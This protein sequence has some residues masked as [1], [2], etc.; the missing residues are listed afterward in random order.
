MKLRYKFFLAFL[1]AGLGIVALL[2]GGMHY[3]ASRNFADY[4]TNEAL[5]RLDDVRER[6]ANEYRVHHGWRRLAVD[7]RL[8]EALLRSP[9]RRY[10]LPPLPSPPPPMNP[11]ASEGPPPQGALPPPPPLMPL[12]RNLVLFDAEKRFVAGRAGTPGNA[13]L[14]AITV[15]GTTV[16]WLGMYPPEHL[17]DPL[18]AG[19]LYRQTRTLAAIGVSIVAVSALLALLLSRH[20]VGP[21]RRVAEGARAMASRRFDV[22][23]DVRTSDEIGELAAD[24][25]RMARTLER[26]EYMRRQ[27]IADLSHELRTPLAILRG[28]IEAV[29]DGV[30]DVRRE[31]FESIHAEVMLLAKIV[32]DLHA[33]TIYESEALAA[34]NQPVAIL[35]IAA[36]V[37]RAFASRFADAAIDVQDD[38]DRGGDLTVQGDPDRLTQVFSNIYENALRYTDA[39]G[40]FRIRHAEE[41]RTLLLTFEDSAPGVPERALPLLFDRLYR[42]DPSRSRRQGGSG[43]GLAI[44][45]AIIEGMGG[46]IA[47]ATSPLG[48]LRIEITLPLERTN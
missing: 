13:V 7:P 34:S 28:E 5:E 11:E 18:Q 45:K 12:L 2:A 16:G 4:V 19:F 8:W 21:I 10:G 17:T 44:S 15:D 26:Y 20:L 31:A 39:P 14:R 41:S 48:G 32:D 35:R 38:L 27:W 43:L 1:L 3:F 6:L 22:S 40:L 24:F 46:T 42:V 25:N 30:R 33:I 23:I 47:A 9:L 36:D 29:L 37:L